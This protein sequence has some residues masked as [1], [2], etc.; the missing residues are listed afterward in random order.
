M[1]GAQVRVSH[2][3]GDGFVAQPFLHRA[4][5]DAITSR[6]AKVCRK[7]CQWKST[8]LASVTITK[9]RIAT[10]TSLKNA[11]LEAVLGSQAICSDRDSTNAFMGYIV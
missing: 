10:H 5:I 2:R 11:F 9:C 6:L 1:L 8:I 3:H 4:N 7:S